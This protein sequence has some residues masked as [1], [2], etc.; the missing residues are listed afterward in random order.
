M[1]EKD[2]TRLEGEELLSARDAAR[3][4]GIS[5]SFLAK[6]RMNG[7]GPRYVKLGRAVRYRRSDL[8]FFVRAHSKSSTAEL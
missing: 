6:S 1:S 8:N 2:S 5:V 3:H 7:T 4:L